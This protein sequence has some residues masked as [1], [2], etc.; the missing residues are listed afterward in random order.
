MLD[1]E[2]IGDWS[3]AYNFDKGSKLFGDRTLTCTDIPE[4]LIGS[5]YIRTACDSKLIL[6][7]LAEFTVAEDSDIYVAMD[8]RVTDPQ[9]SW[10]NDWTKT[11]QFL[12]TVDSQNNTLKLE[13]YK[14]NVKLGEKVILGTNGGSN[15]SVNYVVFANKSTVE[16]KGDVNMDGKFDI[17]DVVLLQ[18]WLLAVPDTKLA[19][20][21]AADLCEDGRLDVF[22]LCLMKRMLIENS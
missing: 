22:D 21:K 16:V 20:W 12:T 8:S 1:N 17:A 13:I 4:N 3:I 18:K 6:S 11:S 10:L 5:E 15:E 14:K 19:N 2:N 7:Q 9:P